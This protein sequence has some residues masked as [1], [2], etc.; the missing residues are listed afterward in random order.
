MSSLWRHLYFDM[1]EN[2]RKLKEG[3]EA[4]FRIIYDAYWNKVF[5]FTRLYL[6]D[7]YQVEDVVQEVFIKLWEIKAQL[8]DERSL[9]G[10]L[11]IITKNKIF[12]QTRRSLNERT[13]MQTLK[14]AEVI[15][16]DIEK[17]IVASDLNEYINKLI[18][19]LPP[20]QQ[21]TF[22][23]SRKLGMSNKEIAERLSISEKGVE[24]NI[25]LALKFIKKRLPFFVVQFFVFCH[26]RGN[27]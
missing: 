22:L 12:N 14:E 10:L 27:I 23:M 4:A 8:D 25:Y 11:F 13:F 2:I 15:S 18:T 20:R 7:S 26:I 17:Q 3:D 6:T 16:C 1:K 19:L 21:E 9:D 5:H 24:R